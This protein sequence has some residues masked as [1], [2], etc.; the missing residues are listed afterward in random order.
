MSLNV[1]LLQ[2][3]LSSWVLNQVCIEDER[4]LPSQG[5]SLFVSVCVSENNLGL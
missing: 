2:N 3:D 4:G 5:S 1:T